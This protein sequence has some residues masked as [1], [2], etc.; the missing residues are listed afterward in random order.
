M[1]RH[2]LPFARKVKP[3]F[4]DHGI[5]S[6]HGQVSVSISVRDANKPQRIEQEKR[7]IYKDNP[8]EKEK[9][10]EENESFHVEPPR[11][12]AWGTKLGRR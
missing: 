3:G 10:A 9:C 8:Q 5:P 11:R 7:D 12:N 6:L 2:D 4:L 1:R